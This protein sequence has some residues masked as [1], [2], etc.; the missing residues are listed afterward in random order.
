[1][2]ACVFPGQGSHFEG[3]GKD[4]YDTFP[5]IRKLYDSYPVIRDVCFYNNNDGL[6]STQLAQQAI[7]LT[8]VAMGKAVMERIQVHSVAG[9]SL[10][11]YSALVCAQA[12]DIEQAIH[13]ISMRGRLMADALAGH[14]T[15][16]MAVLS[17]DYATLVNIVEEV[18]HFGVCTIANINAPTQY[19]LSGDLSVLNLA[20]EKLHKAGIRRVVALK[21][22]GAFHSSYLKE[23]SIAL[24]KALHSIAWQPA[25]CDVVVNVD[26]C[27][28]RDQFIPLLTQ[29]I[30]SP[31]QWMQSLKTLEHQGITTII[32]IGP[33]TTLSSTITSTCSGIRHVRINDVASLRK[34]Y[35][36]GL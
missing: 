35:E 25:Q 1:M 7:L 31:V 18:S 28:H 23:A 11:E 16:M 32:E 33:S 29:Q 30:Y 3:M 21:V 26:A 19:V 5:A 2:I 27:V 22:A 36:E 14:S 20:K 4:V 34:L 10:G 9:L 17:D 15:G 8:S 12:L 13:L 6:A 24:E